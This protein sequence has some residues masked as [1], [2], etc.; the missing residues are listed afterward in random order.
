M[1]HKKANMVCLSVILACFISM[2][3]LTTSLHADKKKGVDI[4]KPILLKAEAYKKMRSRTPRKVLMEAL[5]NFP[6]EQRQ[7]IRK[8]MKAAREETSKKTSTSGEKPLNWKRGVYFSPFRIPKSS[9]DDQPIGH[10]YCTES[11]ISSNY[12]RLLFFEPEGGKGNLSLV[13]TG[14]LL[15][16]QKTTNCLITVKLFNKFGESPAEWVTPYGNDYPI[17]LKFLGKE[18]VLTR[19]TDGSGFVG[20]ATFQGYEPVDGSN[21]GIKTYNASIELLVNK[22]A[23]GQNGKRMDLIAFGGFIIQKF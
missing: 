21:Y 1:K 16:P 7:A 10:I 14:V 5:K 19:L 15:L 3:F 22:W 12:P 13:A 20:I 18:I 17:I 6:Q 2:T 4:A 8:A 11:I 23:A 9:Q